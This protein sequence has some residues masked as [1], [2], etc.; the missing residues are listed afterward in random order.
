MDTAIHG[1]ILAV[2]GSSIQERHKGTG[3][4]RQA[5]LAAVAFVS[6]LLAALMGG[7]SL[8]GT[9]GCGGKESAVALRHEQETLLA[10]QLEQFSCIRQVKVQ[11]APQSWQPGAVIVLEPSRPEAMPD[12]AAL[13]RMLDVLA[14]VPDGP[15][16][17]HVL[18]F[19]TEGRRLYPDRDTDETARREQEMA[20]ERQALRVLRPL[21]ADNGRTEVLVSLDGPGKEK[22]R[23]MGRRTVA[24]LLEENAVP[25][26][27][28]PYLESLL[29]QA[30]ALEEERGD[31]LRLCFLPARRDVAV[32]RGVALAFAV[33]A[34][35][36]MAAFFWTRRRFAVASVS[37]G[38]PV[39][40][41]MP[42]EAGA[43]S[44]APD[45]VDCLRQQVEA[46]I[47]EHPGHGAA[48]L[49]HWLAQEDGIAEGTAGGQGSCN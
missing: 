28:R 33:L 36:S 47:R 37:A 1:G 11:L 19:D 44:G 46:R 26:A 30:C 34:L 35:A 23:A 5:V 16:K 17:R 29:G 12:A 27:V 39:E 8:R 7:L 31:T 13:D 48:L 42:V 24:V 43:D 18:V 45:T 41:S 40:G 2:S 3:R 38:M 6:L 49:R 4:T 32:L 20:L 22:S 25:E 21:L 10:R 14:L 9:G 15:D